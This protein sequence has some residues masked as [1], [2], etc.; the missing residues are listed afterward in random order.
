MLADPSPV[1]SSVSAGR[2]HRS[3]FREIGES[4]GDRSHSSRSSSSR[5]RDSREVQRCAR[6]RFRGLRDRSR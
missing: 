4:T 5:G 2:D 3:R 6:S 1:A